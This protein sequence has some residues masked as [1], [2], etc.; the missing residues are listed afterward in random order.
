MDD[1]NLHGYF[2]DYISVSGNSVSVLVTQDDTQTTEKVTIPSDYYPINTDYKP[3]IFTYDNTPDVIDDPV[4]QRVFNAVPYRIGYCYQNTA[5]LCEILSQLGYKIKSY[6]GWLFVS[7]ELPVFHCWAVLKKGSKRYVLDLADDMTLTSA[8]HSKIRSDSDLIE[9]M[10]YKATLTN[11][12]R[13]HPVGSPSFNIL[14]VGSPC[15]TTEGKAIWNSLIE[16]YPNHKCWRKGKSDKHMSP[17]QE[18]LYDAG[19]MG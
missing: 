13:C 5:A 14:Y 15:D 4:V 12:A 11:C 2:A 16:R 8:N 10:R 1:I 19:L 7:N 3:E 18:K 9:F 6:V 17:F